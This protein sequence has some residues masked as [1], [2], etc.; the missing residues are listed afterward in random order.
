MVVAILVTSFGQI[1]LNR[2][3]QPFYD[4][5]TRRDLNDFL[6]QLGV[7]FVIVGS[8][9]VLDVGQRWLNETI[10]YR[11]REGLTRDLVQLWMAPRRAFWL[12]TSGGPM[13][14]N[15]D[16]RMSEDAQKLCEISTDLSIGLFRS[17]VLLVSFAGVLWTHFRGLHVPRR[18]R[19]LCRAGF[20][21]VGRHFICR[22][23]LAY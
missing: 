6:Y 10:R 1:I 14:V 9:L 3:N 12:A 16:Q 19:R 18:R 5:I 22:G 11:L 21:A 8:L 15:P 17:G 2:W 20:H 13:A 7:Y 23:G 4:A